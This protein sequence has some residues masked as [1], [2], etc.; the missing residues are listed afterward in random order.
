MGKN[1]LEDSII[2]EFEA[3]SEILRA[4]Q[5]QPCNPRVHFNNSVS[6][7]M[8]AMLFGR[9]FELQDPNFTRLTSAL[10]VNVNAIS[11]D[12]LMLNWPFLMWFP[13][14][15]RAIVLQ[16]RSNRIRM[17]NFIR[18]LVANVSGTGETEKFRVAQREGQ[19]AN[20]LD[21]YVRAFQRQQEIEAKETVDEPIF[22]GKANRRYFEIPP[23]VLTFILKSTQKDGSF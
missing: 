9:R 23:C 21:S 14:P 10:A 18:E 8:N 16:A 19:A 3:L 2:T 15:M 6:N 12:Q 11:V 13:N 22:N 17:I 20:D 1:W 4:T 7:V 5:Q